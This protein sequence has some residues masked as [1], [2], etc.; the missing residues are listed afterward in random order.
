MLQYYSNRELSDKLGVNLAKW[1]RW[2]R[3]FLPPDPLGGMQSGFARQYHPDEAFLVHLGGLLVADMKYS[4]PEARQIL[5]DLDE[6]LLNNGFFYDPPGNEKQMEGVENQVE[7]HMIYICCSTD[8]ERKRYDFHYIIKGIIRKKT[9]THDG[10][11]VLEEK[12]VERTVGLR[13]NSNKRVDMIGMRVMNI[14]GVLERFLENLGRDKASYR[15][16]S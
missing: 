8:T 2:S 6:W 5:A 1:K 11:S 10:F 4:I 13:A 16:L 3:E 7:R 9:V 12:Y 15:A 14:T